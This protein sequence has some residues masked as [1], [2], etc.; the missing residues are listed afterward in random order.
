MHPIIVQKRLV[1]RPIQ[2]VADLSIINV[3]NRSDGGLQQEDENH[4]EHVLDG[5]GDERQRDMMTSLFAK[6]TKILL[7]VRECS[8]AD[9]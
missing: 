7:F 2:L 3:G 9:L 5:G 6:F 4:Y 1:Q 8:P